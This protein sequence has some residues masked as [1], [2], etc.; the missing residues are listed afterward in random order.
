MDIT[1]SLLRGLV[2]SVQSAANDPTPEFALGWC[3]QTFGRVNGY[4]SVRGVPNAPNGLFVDCQ[5]AFVSLIGGVRDNNMR[6]NILDGWNNG[7][8]ATSRDGFNPWAYENAVNL[9]DHHMPNVLQPGVRLIMAGHSGGS[10]ITH[11]L[12][13]FRQ[14]R[15]GYPADIVVTTGAP[16]CKR[17]FG[18]FVWP[19]S[20]Y[21]RLMVNTD[22]VCILPPRFNEAPSLVALAG[23]LL[24]GTPIR[25]AIRFLGGNQPNPPFTVWPSYGHSPNGFSMDSLGLIRTS[26]IP[27]AINPDQNILGEPGVTLSNFW[28]LPEHDIAVYVEYLDRHLR[29][30]GDGV[31]VEGVPNVITSG[32]SLFSMPVPLTVEGVADAPNFFLLPV[33]LGENFILPVDGGRINPVAAPIQVGDMPNPDGGSLGALYLRGELVAIFPTRSKARTA[34]RYLNKFLARLPAAGEVS[35]G[36]MSDGI[37]AYLRDAAAGGGVDKRPVRVV[38]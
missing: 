25:S 5:D 4:T 28:G 24:L 3:K 21:C 26:D 7:V 14:R 27:G 35:L 16:R 32:T 37:S 30:F 15:Q 6:L 33:D 17:T 22:P 38:S 20:L 1:T 34:A 18:D 36:G 9:F 8:G 29:K 11:V 19:S 13:S 12:N 10:M 31:I 23:G 2:R